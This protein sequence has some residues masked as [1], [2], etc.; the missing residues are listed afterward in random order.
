MNIWHDIKKERITPGDFVAVIEIPTGSKQKYELD[1]DTGFLML[2]RIL[3]TS[4]HYPA[5]YGFIPRTFGFDHDPLDVLV[6]CTQTIAPL[7]L[8]RC[9]PIGVITMLDGRKR[10]EKIIAL[11]FADPNYAGVDSIEQLSPHIFD[12]IRHFFEVYKMLEN[13]Q[14]IVDDEVRGKKEAIRV[15]EKAID[16]YRE[17]FIR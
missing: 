7:T 12:E 10:D 17:K 15:I 5:N 1:K 8:V 11:P 4:T 14:T 6:L 13:K 3:Y 2:D 9:H 16:D